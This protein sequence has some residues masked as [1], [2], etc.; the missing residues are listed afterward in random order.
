MVDFGHLSDNLSNRE[1]ELTDRAEQITLKNVSRKLEIQPLIIAAWISYLK[2][3]SLKPNK[4]R[5]I[6]EWIFE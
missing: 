1:C 6:L 2:N 4:P 5:Y 3:K